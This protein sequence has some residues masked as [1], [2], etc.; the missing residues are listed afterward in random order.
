MVGPAAEPVWVGD[1]Y[2]GRT[3]INGRQIGGAIY[4]RN[5]PPRGECWMVN[6]TLSMQESVR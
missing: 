1:Y 5:S 2:V 6:F 4:P 3:I